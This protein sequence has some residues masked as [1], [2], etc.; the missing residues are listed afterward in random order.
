[1]LGY[2][3]TF[4]IDMSL[5]VSTDRDHVV[6]NVLA[7]GLTWLRQTKGD[8]DV[9]SVE[10]GQLTTLESGREVVYVHE[11]QK[12]GSEYARLI[13]MDPPESDGQRWVTSLLVGIDHRKDSRQH[14]SWPAIA[15]EIDAPPDP[16]VPTRARWTSRPRLV[17]RILGAYV[18]DDH[19]FLM[20]DTPRRIDEE[21]VDELMVQLR[22]T[23]HHGLVILCGE[24]G[25]VPR[26]V[27]R[28]RLQRITRETLGQASTFLLT[29]D[30]MRLF[31]ESVS[32]AHALAPYCPRTFRPGA[33]LD[34]PHD[35]YRHRFLTMETLLGK[36]L[37]D[38]TRSF[39][40]ASREHANQQPLDRPLRRLDEISSIRLD[41]ITRTAALG[42]HA[43]SVASNRH[44]TR[45]PVTLPPAGPMGVETDLEAPADIDVTPS[46][47]HLDPGRVADSA[48]IDD[49]VMESRGAGAGDARVSGSDRE[50][51]TTDPAPS[52]A[53]LEA[54]ATLE[55]RVAS[56]TAALDQ[57]E[58]ELREAHAESE[59]IREEAESRAVRSRDE[60]DAVQKDLRSRL[61][62]EQLERAI[63]DS[64]MRETERELRQVQLRLE[65]ARRLMAQNHISDDASWLEPA[66]DAYGEP[67][68]SWEDLQTYA[69]M[70]IFDHLRFVGE[71]EDARDLADHDAT[72]QWVH[73]TWDSLA[74]LNDYAR[75]RTSE[76]ATFDGGLKEFIEGRAPAGS[77]LIPAGRVRFNES[78]TVRGRK[79][80]MRERACRVPAEVDPSGTLEMVSHIVIQ[81]RGS[82]CPR[83]YFA[84]RT[85]DLGQVLV[86]RIGSHPT[87]TKTS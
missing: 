66:E 13:A 31:N 16:N 5:T 4:S 56:L 68:D 18:C 9:D 19:G 85:A 22:E 33:V 67:V 39:G 62:D 55:T 75:C 78:E 58:A 70:D 11:R 45:G 81:T 84:D 10:P 50:L 24:D 80:W 7:D 72:G 51:P 26:D 37:A 64:D 47:T 29:E 25:T 1:M 77:H 6:S 63:L 48:P 43:S 61:E 42:S 30:A 59:R 79:D 15:V 34:D 8:R 21:L 12:S 74:M 2:R 54:L 71:W 83:L 65:A 57:R 44:T 60:S 52:E 73:L 40:R 14:E 87:N 41:D 36:R 3:S 46:T 32:P 82:V 23:D 17:Q 20:G 53:T 35:A 76:D 49:D 69:E 86:G 38:L 27:W 28:D